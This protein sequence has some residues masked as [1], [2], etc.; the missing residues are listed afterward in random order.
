MEDAL[1]SL[2]LLLIVAKLAEGLATRLGQSSLMAYVLTGIVLGPALG[3]VEVQADLT[4]FFGIGVVFLFFLIGVDE[5]DISGF[6]ETL[7]GR[8]FLAALVAFLIPMAASLAVTYYA[9]DLSMAPAIAVSGLISLSSLG[10][11]AKVLGD[12][13][14]LKEPLGLE[15]FTTVVIVELV[16]L[17][18]VGFTLEEVVSPGDF[19]AWKIPL[20]L[21]QIAGFALVSWV[22]A[23]RLFPPLL[24]RPRRILGVPQ[25]S[26]GL[27]I[28]GLFLVVVGADK[29]GLHGSLGALL[30][31]TALSGLP[32]RL[33]SEVLPGVRS[34]A[35]GLFIPLFFASAGL[36][37][38]TS[39]TALSVLA[40]VSLVTVTVLGKFIGSTLAA[41]VARLDAPLAFASGLMAKGVVEVALLLVMLEADVISQE[42]FSL[43]TVIMLGFIFLV[44]PLMGFAVSR[45]RIS[46]EPHT[47]RDVVPFLRAIRPGRR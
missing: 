35:Q 22:L 46:A 5:L 8:F 14:H 7:R 47:P 11:V 4:L 26:F 18:V 43:L 30:L 2:A 13:G 28:G 40:I 10:V 45:A 16:G 39:F 24:I 41:Y 31:G 27:L 23:S 9:L 1:L 19:R 38:D 25:L 33:R 3:V 17:L 32:H 20:L 29:I 21:A 42:V 37:L 12:L 44:P 6:V 36:N 34:M 15:I